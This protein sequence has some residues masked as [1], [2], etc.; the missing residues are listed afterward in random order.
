MLAAWRLSCFPLWPGDPQA[1]SWFV[2]SDILTSIVLS[3]VAPP[4]GGLPGFTP[5][6]RGLRAY[7]T[8]GL[9]RSSWRLYSRS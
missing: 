3:S 4:V 1:A 5:C 7:R 8:G 9:Y 2:F 6:R